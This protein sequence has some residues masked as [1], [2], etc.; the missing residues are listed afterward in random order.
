LVVVVE[1]VIM[2][3]S[4]QHHLVEVVAVVVAKVGSTA[5]PE[6]LVQEVK[7]ILVDMVLPMLVAVVVEQVRQ[8]MLLLQGAVQAVMEVQVHHRL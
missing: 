5:D 3:Q 2:V 4:W 1:D 6:H 8:V 7:V